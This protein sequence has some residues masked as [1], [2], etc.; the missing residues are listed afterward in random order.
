[1]NPIPT[2]TPYAYQ[3]VEYITALNPSDWSIWNYTDEAIQIWNYDPNLGLVVQVGIIVVIVVI[4]VALMI[5][6]IQDTMSEG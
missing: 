3:T 1:M 4:F 2:P 5:R 6:L